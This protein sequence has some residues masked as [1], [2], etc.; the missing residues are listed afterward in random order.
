MQY[1][2]IDN[3]K[4]FSVCFR[5]LTIEWEAK[6]S[7]IASIALHKYEKSVCEICTSTIDNRK[8]SI[9]SHVVATKSTIKTIPERISS[10][11]LRKQKIMSRE[12]EISTRAMS[13]LIRDVF[14]MKA[15]CRSTG[16]LLTTHK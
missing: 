4:Q 12:T 2:L 16:H 15:C 9:R 7:R 10:I 3:I 8:K 13:R 1:L 11:T 6:E 5:L 14:H